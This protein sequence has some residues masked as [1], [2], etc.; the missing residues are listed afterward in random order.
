MK[1]CTAS[2]NRIPTT[3]P[4]CMMIKDAGALL[5]AADAAFPADGGAPPSAFKGG[6]VPIIISPVHSYLDA[7]PR[8]SFL[9]LASIEKVATPSSLSFY[10]VVA[11][12]R[13]S[14]RIFGITIT[15]KMQSELL[16]GEGPVRNSTF[17][18]ST[19]RTEARARLPQA[20]YDQ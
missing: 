1:L 2:I 8:R 7:F 13:C 16:L 9:H 15:R 5:S 3:E 6:G 14:R 12:P 17:A 19:P 20:S 18:I 11:R 4:A 10:E